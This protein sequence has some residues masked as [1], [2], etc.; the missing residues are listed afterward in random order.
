MRVVLASKNK[1]KLEE[2]SKITEK[3]GIDLVPQ[4]E[5]GVDPAAEENGTQEKSYELTK[6]NI[7][8]SSKSAVLMEA[9]SG[10]I[11]FSKNENY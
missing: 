4:S 6:Q 11:I 1:H 3:F 8:I 9:E 10:E 5:P 2:I 7:E